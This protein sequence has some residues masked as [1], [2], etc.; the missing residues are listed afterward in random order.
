ARGQGHVPPRRIGLQNVKKGRNRFP[1][2]CCNVATHVRRPPKDA[3]NAATLVRRPP[4]GR[5]QRCNTH[6]AA[7]ASALATLHH[8][9]G[10]R[11]ER[12]CNAAP[13]VRR[14][15]EG[16]CNAAT[17]LWTTPQ[18][19]SQRCNTLLA[20]F[21]DRQALHE[22]NFADTRGQLLLRLERLGPFR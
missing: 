6:R 9:F 11:L 22:K 21:F 18:R 13:Y 4:Q 17:H 8:T 3:C 15:P 5:L 1:N 12:S 10:A 19:L 2:R 20:L 7:V 16:T 14:P